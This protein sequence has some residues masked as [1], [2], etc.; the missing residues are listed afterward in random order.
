[1]ISVGINSGFVEI[2]FIL[3]F[4]RVMFPAAPLYGISN[5][6]NIEDGT[7]TLL[8]VR[9]REVGRE[10]GREHRKDIPS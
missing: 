2:F 6:Q 10:G 8:K 5:K 1:M 9:W 4:L 3:S 7:R